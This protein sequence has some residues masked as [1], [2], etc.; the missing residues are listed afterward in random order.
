M[1]AQD[2]IRLYHMLE[3]VQAAISFADGETRES[4]E[5]DL[6]L[7]FALIRALEIIGEAASRLTKECQTAYP[8]IPWPAIIGMRNW[9]V[10][11]YFDID[12][13]QVWDTIQKD[14]PPLVVQLESLVSPDDDIEES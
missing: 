5:T 13:D 8:E 3:A 14:L 11:A 6:K 2:K 4:L 1:N 9:L 10:H 7:R 12:L